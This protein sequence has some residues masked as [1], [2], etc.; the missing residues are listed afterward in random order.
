MKKLDS[1]KQET[2]DE[3]RNINHLASKLVPHLNNSITTALQHLAWT[4]IFHLF[5][6]VPSSFLP[7]SILHEDPNSVAFIPLY[8]VP[9]CA[10]TQLSPP[11]C[12]K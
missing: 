4:S 9:N 5:L 1:I 7:L 6:A 3:D 10:A 8:Q 2:K 11:P 12:N